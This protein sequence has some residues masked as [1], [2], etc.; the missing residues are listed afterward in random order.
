VSNEPKQVDRAG[1]YQKHHHDRNSLEPGVRF[2]KHPVFLFDFVL[3]SADVDAS[4]IVRDVIPGIG[5]VRGGKL[6]KIPQVTVCRGDARTPI[7]VSAPER[8]RAFALSFNPLR[9]LIKV[10]VR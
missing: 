1:C 4:T 8:G 7:I 9:R 3:D 6:S 10:L 5:E 2:F